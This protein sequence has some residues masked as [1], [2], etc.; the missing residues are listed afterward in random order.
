MCLA[1]V[2]HSSGPARATPAGAASSPAPAPERKPARGAPSLAWRLAPG[3]ALPDPGVR[4]GATRTKLCDLGQ[5]M[6]AA[7]PTPFHLDPVFRRPPEAARAA[8]AAALKRVETS[9][10]GSAPARAAAAEVTRLLRGADG[11]AL[12]RMALLHP[13]PRGRAAAL[14]AA[15]PLVPDHPRLAGFAAGDLRAKDAA[16]ARVAVRFSFAAR[17]DTPALYAMDGLE[18]PAVAVR[19]STVRALAA[20]TPG[21][22]DTGL[23]TILARHVTEAERAPRVR[24]LFA[25]AVGQLGWLPA[26]P[27]LQRL[28]K[29]ESATVQHE[30]AVALTR[31][32]GAPPPGV[33]RWARSRSVAGRLA[34]VR[35]LAASQSAVALRQAVAGLTKD[36]R[37]LRDPLARAGVDRAPRWQVATQAQR[38]LDWAALTH[39]PTGPQAHLLAP[40]PR[41]SP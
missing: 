11:P 36:R 5:H 4:L 15:L 29:D 25:R 30:A 32:T 31:L 33:L 35:A 34:A 2:A 14:R 10:P 17:C 41:S 16:R 12:A 37:A 8:M 18:H 13:G 40:A 38:A 9:K 3:V 21:T 23:W 7:E 22:D 19:E 1:V 20:L 6:L 39:P 28:L 27:A 24:A 26:I